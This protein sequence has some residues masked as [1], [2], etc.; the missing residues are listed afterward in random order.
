ML[1]IDELTFDFIDKLQKGNNGYKLFT[2]IP[3]IYIDS[4]FQLSNSYNYNLSFTLQP[5]ELKRGLDLDYFFQRPFVLGSEGMRILVQN[6]D[7]VNG[8]Q[9]INDNR[10]CDFN[11]EV[12]AFKGD[13]DETLWDKSKQT[14]YFK[15]DKNNFSSSKS[16]IQFDLTTDSNNNGFYN[17]IQ[18][19]VDNVELLFYHESVSAESGYYI[20]RPKGL[21]NFSKFKQIIDSTISAFG[22]LNGFYMHDTV[23]FFAYKEIDGKSIMTYRY[24]NSKLSFNTNTPIIDSGHYGDI[25]IESLRLS[26]KQFNNLVNLFYGNE[27][28]LRSALLL[29]NAGKLKGCAKASLGAVALETITKKI[30]TDSLNSEIIEDKKLIR[31]LRYQLNKTLKNFSEKIN[32]EDLSIL[33][34]KLNQI[35]NKPNASKLEEAFYH[36]NI[37]L[38]EDEKYCISCRNLFLHGNLPRRKKDMWMTDLEL[39]DIVANRLVMLSSILLLKLAN[40]N[41]MVIDRGMT[42]VT[43]WRMIRQGKKVGGGNCLRSIV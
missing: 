32:K 3:N 1:N 12:K 41:G 27:E 16:G 13:T 38:D 24:E 15:Y 11:I 36:L 37:S 18:L 6:I 29:I 7:I 20:F 21:I 34:T 22:F 40:F 33:S 2:T 14:A 25:S 10:P 31:G 39:L 5:D 9:G 28:Y 30:G 42:D 43:K 26:S 4:T 17:A 8:S 19:N 35:N 23:Y